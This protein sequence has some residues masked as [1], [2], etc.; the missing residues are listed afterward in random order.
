MRRVCRTS[1]KVWYTNTPWEP[2]QIGGPEGCHRAVH[3]RYIP[4][5]TTTIHYSKQVQ[6]RACFTWL[7]VGPCRH[8]KVSTV[9]G[10]FDPWS[11]FDYRKT[12]YPDVYDPNE[13][14]LCTRYKVRHGGNAVRQRGGYAP[15]TLVPLALVLL[16]F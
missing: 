7:H 14:L 12:I 1:P 2:G 4:G 9:G 11:F 13:A 6:L 8:M 15:L 10:R 5:T 3:P 16:A